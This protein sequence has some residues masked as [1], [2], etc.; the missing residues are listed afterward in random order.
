MKK[1]IAILLL[2]ILSFAT[3]SLAA[4][5][6]WEPMPADQTTI[7]VAATPNSKDK[8]IAF[9]LTGVVMFARYSRVKFPFPSKK[10]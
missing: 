5:N 7:T 3:L 8:A 4:C 10:A 2:A 6:K 1:V 9:K